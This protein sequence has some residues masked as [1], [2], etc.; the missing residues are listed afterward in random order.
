VVV[1]EQAAR[2]AARAATVEALAARE[3]DEAGCVVTSAA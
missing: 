1:E 2:R 3:A